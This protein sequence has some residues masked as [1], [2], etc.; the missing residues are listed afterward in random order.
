MSKSAPPV[1]RSPE[2]GWK[3][4]VKTSF[5]LCYEISKEISKNGY[6]IITNI[7]KIITNHLKLIKLII[8]RR[9][10]RGDEKRRPGEKGRATST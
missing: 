9:R 5:V 6:E 2:W 7:I 8:M 3:S 10:N 4:R 1:A